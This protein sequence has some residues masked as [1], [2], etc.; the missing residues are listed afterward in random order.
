MLS[1]EEALARIT[2]KELAMKA[3]LVAQHGLP[4]GRPLPMDR[5][6]SRFMIGMAGRI[7]L[8]TTLGAVAENGHP[9]L[10]PLGIPGRGRAL[11]RFA[12]ISYPRYGQELVGPWAMEHYGVTDQAEL[13]RRAS[14]RALDEATWKNPEV[15][16]LHNADD[17][18]L[19][20]DG[21][22]FLER[23]AGDRLTVFPGGDHLGNLHLPEVAISGTSTSRTFRRP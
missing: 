11:D 18:I 3:F 9:V 1:V 13:E 10:T 20:D 6:E 5:E 23:H 4:E 12:S 14:L 21:L 19:G 8:S 17:F 15:R 16:I 22:A 2:I 7:T